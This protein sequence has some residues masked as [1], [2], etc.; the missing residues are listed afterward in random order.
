MI[1]PIQFDVA[2]GW[3]EYLS[4]TRELVLPYVNQ[5]RQK[6]G[7]PAVTERDWILRLT[8]GLFATPI[9]FYKVA[10]V[11]SCK[12]SIDGGQMTR[13]AKDGTLTCPWSDII[14]VRR[15]ESGYLVMKTDGAMPLPYRCFSAEQRAGFDE[16]LSRLG[17]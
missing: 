8:H 11:G 14:E 15:F 6:K 7:K 12:F 13:V 10:R 16:L 4:F 5:D 9:F 1:A 3:L 2:Y 17:K